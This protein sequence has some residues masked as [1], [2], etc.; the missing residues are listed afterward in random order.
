MCYMTLPPRRSLRLEY[1]LHVAHEIEGYK[2]AVSVTHLC[3]IADAAL[4]E[5]ETREQSEIR[6][7]TLAAEVDRLIVRRLKLPSFATWQ[8]RCL[9]SAADP[10]H[11]SHWGLPAN[12]PVTLLTLNSVPGAAV[13]VGGAGIVANALY[14]A[15]QGCQ[16]VATDVDA[17]LVDRVL[18]LAD[19]SGLGA[20]VQGVVGALVEG[21]ECAEIGALVTS[22][23]AF[24]GLCERERAMWIDLLQRH[25]VTGGV[26]LFESL[27]NE[28]SALTSEEIA[29][30]YAVWGGV[31]QRYRSD[32][33]LFSATKQTLPA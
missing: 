14:L 8:R 32:V 17:A 9:T 7:V 31:F 15:A 6:E 4:R 5:L 23:S 20:R 12:A 33:G 3:R 22:P 24:A 26:H 29:G 27:C 21:V 25:T 30:H 18:S 1:Q 13:V 16:V 2:E 11:P 10:R 28:H 19:A